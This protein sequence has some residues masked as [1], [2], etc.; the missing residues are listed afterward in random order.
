MSTKLVK[1]DQTIQSNRSPHKTSS[2]KRE[3]SLPQIKGRDE[4]IEQ[5]EI[6]RP[7]ADSVETTPLPISSRKNDLVVLQSGAAEVGQGL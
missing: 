3:G 4:L 6:L 5:I 2:V 1:F 7:K